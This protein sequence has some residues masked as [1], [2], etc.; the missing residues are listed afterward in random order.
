MSKNQQLIQN[1][2]NTKGLSNG[3][4]K[5]AAYPVTLASPHYSNQVRTLG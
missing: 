4:N 5:T 1:N 2:K 3:S